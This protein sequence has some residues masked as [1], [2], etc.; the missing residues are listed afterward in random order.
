MVEH[1]NE[2]KLLEVLLATRNLA[3]ADE[4]ISLKDILK[5]IEIMLLR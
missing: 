1:L 2:A 5:Q 4:T 3:D